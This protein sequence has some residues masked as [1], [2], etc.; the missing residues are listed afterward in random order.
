MFTYGTPKTYRTEFIAM[1]V[2][3][4]VM[5]LFYFFGGL[6]MYIYIYVYNTTFWAQ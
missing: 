1:I 3:C 4:D 6:N 2:G 5:W